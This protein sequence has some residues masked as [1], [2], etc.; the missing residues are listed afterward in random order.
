MDFV[1][2]DWVD[3]PTETTPITSAELERIEAGVVEGISKAE[4]TASE[5]TPGRVELASPAEMTT[6]TDLSRVPS[7]KRVADY[8]AAAVAAVTGSSGATE[9]A[10]G[11]VELASAAEMT[12]G[13]DLTRT[14]AV[15]RV[16]DYVTAAVAALSTST[17]AA[18]AALSAATT[19]ALGGK[20]D[21]TGSVNQF[22]DVSNAPF[23]DGDILIVET[24]VLEPVDASGTFAG[25]DANLRLD[26]GAF[27]QYYVPTIIIEEGQVPP[28]T[29]PAYGL[30]GKL[31]A[32]ASLIPIFLDVDSVRAANNVVL[33]LPDA[34]VAGDYIGFSL[35][36][37]DST[38]F[39][40]ISAAF[41]GTGPG[42][43]TFDFGTLS[44]PNTTAG[45]LN[46]F[47]KL[48]SGAAAGSSIT[49]TARDA[50]NNAINR[51]HLIAAIYQMPN[52]VSSSPRDQ[53]Q[54]GGG[55]STTNLAGITVA[56]GVDTTTPNQI[57]IGC[58]ANSAG[59]APNIRDIAGTSG[60]QLIANHL[61]DN[62]SNGRRL[63]VGYKVLT[64]PGR[65]VLTTQVT[66][67]GTATQTGLWAGKIDTYKGI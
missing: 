17:N 31:P 64:A 44:V 25:L 2:K 38:P 29:F 56:I 35:A 45:C 59:T 15:K 19:S 23:N 57:A 43:G 1:P 42:S 33:Q 3:E 22:A 30:V 46:G 65:P 11:I 28:G 7:V 41:T 48:T 4:T 24:G 58:A 47:V 21:K 53:Q 60:W 13:T 12:A 27:P 14:P 26:P 61:S 6:G 32:A 5:V 34:L 51:V 8:V 50:S 10:A 40:H 66:L 39:D 49:F 37:D 36:W 9:S 55:P 20:A 18:I 63:Y 16:A 52:L 54:A 67:S 62:G